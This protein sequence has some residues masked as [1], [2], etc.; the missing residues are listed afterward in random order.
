MSKKRDYDL[1]ATKQLYYDYLESGKQI[2]EFTQ[3]EATIKIEDLSRKKILNRIYRLVDNIIE[4][5]YK[6]G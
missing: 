4:Q 1:K 6:S 3:P 5:I 2:K